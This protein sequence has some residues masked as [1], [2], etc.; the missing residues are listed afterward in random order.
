MYEAGELPASNRGPSVMATSPRTRN[1]V[2]QGYL[3]ADRLSRYYYRLA[4]RY[5]SISKWIQFAMAFAALGGIARLTGML[6]AGWT[7]LSDAAALAMLALVVWNLIAGYPRKAAVLH[8]IS[9]QCAEYERQWRAL[10]NEVDVEGADEWAILA[11][12]QDLGAGML[13]TTSAA[14][15]VGV[16]EHSKLN[17]RA[18]AEAYR[19]ISDRYAVESNAN[20]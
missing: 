16:K 17:E 5:E 2:W 4:G 15:D 19:A 12:A 13:K 14:T 3:D 6:P 11:R 10:W 9:F 7:W 1:E 20:G 8:A 18:A